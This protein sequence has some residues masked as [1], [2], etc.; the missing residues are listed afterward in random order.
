MTEAKTILK[1][2]EEV[3]PDDTAKLDEIDVLVFRYCGDGCYPAI[4][5]P[6]SPFPRYTRD[7][8]LL[9][10]IRPEGFKTWALF[11]GYKEGAKFRAEM[12]T[13]EMHE[14]A[15]KYVCDKPHIIQTGW[16]PTEELAELHAIISAIEYERNN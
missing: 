7:R 9:K 13:P 2:I 10:A 3:S 14:E 8:N 4:P 11:D 1:L 6:N 12:F 5:L 16:L 15:K